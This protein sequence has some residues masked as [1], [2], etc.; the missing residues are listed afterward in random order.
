RADDPPR[1][2]VDRRDHERDLDEA[3]V[4]AT[5]H[6]LV[7]IDALAATDALED[8]GLLVRPV[9]R[10]ENYDRTAHGFLGR[11][12]VDALGTAVPAR[13]DAVEVRADDRIVAR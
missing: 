4:L 10:N 8:G 11:V 13:D 9:I 6:R 3:A 1:A 2:V 5:T 7:M 12:A